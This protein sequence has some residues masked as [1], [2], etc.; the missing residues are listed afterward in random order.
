LVNI[1]SYKKCSSTIS[2]QGREKS[3][4]KSSIRAH[5]IEVVERVPL[6]TGVNN[7]NQ[8]YMDTKRDK[9]AHMI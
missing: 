2:L 4:R 8:G 9:F 6:I 7:V 1:E 5:G 3:V